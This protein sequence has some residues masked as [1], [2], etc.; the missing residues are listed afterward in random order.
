MATGI[1]IADGLFNLGFGKGIQLPSV[2]GGPGGCTPQGL[3]WSS[4]P[5]TANIFYQPA[6]G[7]YNYSVA[8][9]IFL[10]AEMAAGINCINGLEFEV[11]GYSTPYTYN[12]F[13]IKLA[14]VQ[15]SFFGTAVTV[16]L[17]NLTVSDV[18]IVKENFNLTIANSG[19]QTVDFD[20][21]FEWNGTDNILVIYENRDGVYASG[22]GWGE[23]RSQ[24]AG[25]NRTAY[26]FQDGS[27]P[28]NST[29]LSV[30]YRR[31]NITFKY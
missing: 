24:G 18:T 10:A 19:L 27:Y 7:L 20:N 8:M 4:T 9:N 13:T 5:G 3:T 2:G 26:K 29:V 1:S 17:D 16:G 22:Y 15:N 31:L 23:T 25:T 30:D 21:N 6:Y 12:N 14:H 28:S 11:N